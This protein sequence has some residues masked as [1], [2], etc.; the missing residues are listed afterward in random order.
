M[1]DLIRLSVSRGH[2]IFHEEVARDG[3]QGKSFLSAH[4]R[5]AA[6]RSHA[7]ILGPEAQER[8]VFMAGFPSAS[9][10]E[11][12]AVR[13]VVQQVDSCYLGVAGRCSTADVDCMLAALAGVRYGRMVVILPTSRAT[14][15]ALTRQSPEQCLQTAVDVIRYAVS[16][17][18]GLPVDFAMLD[19]NRAEPGFLAEVIRTLLAA[20]ASMGIVCDTVGA[21]LPGETYRFFTE[22]KRQLPADV[23]LVCHLHNDLG[24]G[25]INTLEALR[26]GV[27]GLTSSWLGL[28]E[29]AGMPPTEQL[30]FNLAYRFDDLRQDLGLP[31]R[32]HMGPCDLRKIVPLAHRLSEVMHVPL[33]TT[34]PIVGSGVNTISTGT[35]FTNPAAFQ[36]YDPEA[37]LGVKR[38]VLLT[39]LASKRVV[40][41]VAQ[42]LGYTLDDAGADQALAWVKA[43]VYRRHLASLSKAEFKA[44]LQRQQ[45]QQQRLQPQDDAVPG[46]AK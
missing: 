11:F 44:F 27:L 17:S 4:D 22:L 15:T 13:Q 3:A 31:E 38:S 20:G 24:F 37:V 18:S 42:E 14:C 41:Y 34:D 6:A 25:L 45:E 9:Q 29:R 19:S 35:P 8:L 10:E 33:R 30:L 21:L 46:Y 39:A 26:A 32:Y 23:P 40:T 36:P 2:I 16:R 43:E 7:D 28:G 1:V 5:V 12:A